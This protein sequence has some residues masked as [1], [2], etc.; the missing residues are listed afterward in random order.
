M[1]ELEAAQALFG[2]TPSLTTPNSSSASPTNNTTTIS[3][4][5]TGD[6]DSGT[7]QVQIDGET[8]DIDT[9]VPVKEGDSLLIS[10]TNNIP[11]V[12]GV[13]GGGDRTEERIDALLSVV[14]EELI[15]FNASSW[16]F[17]VA[18]ETKASNFECS[19]ENGLVILKC[20]A[21][22][23]ESEETV[24][25]D[26]SLDAPDAN[27]EP[28]TVTVT[29]TSNRF[30][31][32][33]EQPIPFDGD[34]LIHVESMPNHIDGEIL[35]GGSVARESDVYDGLPEEELE[36]PEDVEEGITVQE[37]EIVE[38]DAEEEPQMVEEYEDIA[39]FPLTGGDALV[40]L[41]GDY[42]LFVQIGESFTPGEV[43]EGFKMSFRAVNRIAED[44]AITKA[45]VDAA[46]AKQDAAQAVGAS[47][48]AKLLAEAAQ[49]AASQASAAITP[50]LN[51]LYEIQGEEET[52]VAG[53]EKKVNTMTADFASA[54]ELAQVQKNFETSIAQTAAKIEMVA[55]SDTALQLTEEAQ[56]KL[57]MANAELATATVNLEAAQNAYDNAV[58]SYNELLVNEQATEEQ[59]SQAEQAVTDAQYVLEAAKRAYK[60]ITDLI[61][62]IKT[63]YASK[64]EFNLM[65]KGL[66]LLFSTEEENQDEDPDEEQPAAKERTSYVTIT[67]GGIQLGEVGDPD[68]YLNIASKAIEF[69]Q[70]GGVVAKIE[71]DVMEITRVK[72]TDELAI[73]S[74]EQKTMWRWK[75]RDNG[76]ISF[77]WRSE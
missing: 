50:I 76:N 13:V 26:A 64:T 10:V 61:A 58:E 54:K 52:F 33:S 3:G 18:D 57:T 53:L 70:N 27:D 63:N 42:R 40:T 72:L 48:E 20:D 9:T 74:E 69:Y 2:S 14:G 1:D 17:G 29:D 4:I 24:S 59:L 30:L 77:K 62:G 68:N 60:N 15:D 37:E 35:I 75:Q 73:G 16:T 31:I 43:I 39:S 19:I 46:K 25:N 36:R 47:E 22:A 56:T 66:E 28:E 71:D 41:R 32:E 11:V 55:S 51:N 38:E 12:T 5:A 44:G 67:K 34:V 65:A 21:V 8:V 7:V 23:I 6:S 45:Q 49:T